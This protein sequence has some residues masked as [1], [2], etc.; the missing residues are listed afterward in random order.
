M[1]NATI[2][3]LDP[4]F[5]AQDYERV[6]LQEIDS[7]QCLRNWK[8]DLPIGNRECSKMRWNRD[9]ALDH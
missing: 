1:A 7:F 6:L 2:G 9:V 4:A 8:H 5:P 3:G